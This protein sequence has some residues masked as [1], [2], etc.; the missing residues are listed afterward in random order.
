MEKGPKRSGKPVDKKRKLLSI[1]EQMDSLL[2]E[3]SDI[4]QEVRQAIATARDTAWQ[5]F[6]KV[7]EQINSTNR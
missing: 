5:A 6:V 1:K 2:A 7:H 3:S 4:S